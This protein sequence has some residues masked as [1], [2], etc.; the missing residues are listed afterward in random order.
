MAENDLGTLQYEMIVSD[1]KLKKSLDAITLQIKE[2]EKIWNEAFKNVGAG[3]TIDVSKIAQSAQKITQIEALE[4]GKQAQSWKQFVKERMS[5]YMR[6]EGSHAGAM[7]R[8]SSEWSVYKNS[9]S[10]NGSSK[11]TDAIV[12]SIQKLEKELAEAVIAYKKLSD[13]QRNDEGGRQALSSIQKQKDQLNEFNKTLKANIAARNEAA[14]AELAQQS[15]KASLESQ[16]SKAFVKSN[17]DKEK[18][19]TAEL[20]KQEAALRSLE[21]QR[22][23]AFVQGNLQK[24]KELTAEIRRQESAMRALEAQRSKAFVSQ[25]NKD[26]RDRLAAE[27]ALAAEQR[28]KIAVDAQEAGSIGRLRAENALMAFQIRKLNPLIA[29]EAAEILRLNQAMGANARQVQALQPTLGL[30]GKL[31]SAIRTYATAYLSV[32]AVMGLGKAVYNQ[33]KELDQLDFGMKT[34][35]KSSVE[36]ANTQKFLSEVAVNYGGDLL[37]LSERYIKFR[38]AAQQSN[39]SAAETQKIFDSMSKAAGTLGIKTD[40]LSGVYLALEQM[41]SKG[42]VTTEELRRQLGERLPGAFG[43]M[44]N[45]LGV[46][47]PEL[48]KML[49]KGEV[50]SKDALP[51]FADAIE[52]A[53]G[54][55][56]LKKIDTLAAAQGRMSTEFT[57]LIQAMNMGDAFKGTLNSIA[58]FLGYIKDNIGAIKL[59]VNSL[60]LIG[61]AYTANTLG[62]RAFNAVSQLFFRQLTVVTLATGRQIVVTNQAAVAQNVFTNAVIRAKTAFNNLGV[63]I[64]SN[65]VGLLVGAL[66]SAVTYFALMRG[67]TKKIADAMGDLNKEED[68]LVR[69]L[70]YQKKVVKEAGSETNR[71]TSAIK[72]VNTVALKYNQALVTQ[73]D[74]QDKINASINETIRLIKLEYL[75]KRKAKLLEQAET[76][77]AIPLDK[78]RETL[79]SMFDPSEAYDKFVQFQEMVAKGA[80]NTDILS[81]A[82]GNKKIYDDR[83]FIE[84]I[85]AE[86]EYLKKKAEIEAKYKTSTKEDVIAF[87]V[88]ALKKNISDAKDEFERLEE[89][90]KVGGKLAAPDFSLDFKSNKEYLNSLLVEYAKF[91]EAMELINLELAKLE[92]DKKTGAGSEDKIAERRREAL[93]KLNDRYLA[94][95]QEFADF[96]AGISAGR[97]A[98]MEDS[99]EKELKLNELAYANRL[100][101]IE[102]DKILTLSLLNDA[103]DPK[104]PIITSLDAT[105]YDAKT[106]GVIDNARGADAQ[107]R[108]NAEQ[109]L[110]EANLKSEKDYAYKIKEIRRD[111]NDQFLTGLEKEIAANNEKYDAWAKKALE[112]GEWELLAQIERARSTANDELFRQ[113]ELDQLDF[114]REIEYKK[115]E[116]ANKGSLN[117]RKLDRANFESYARFERDKIRIMKS[118]ANKDT[119]EQG[120]LAEENLLMDQKLFKIKQ[121]ADLRTQIIDGAKKLSGILAEQLGLSEQQAD[122]LNGLSSVFDDILSGNLISAAVGAFGTAIDAINGGEDSPTITALEKINHLLEQQSAIL[123]SLSGGNYFLL[124]KKQLNDYQLQIQETTKELKRDLATTS[125]GGLFANPNNLDP[126]SSQYIREREALVNRV[127]NLVNDETKGL[128]SVFMLWQSGALKLNDAQ[129]SA[130]QA[131]IEAEQ[132]II[133]LQ[134]EIYS[135][136]LGFTAADVADS[137]FTGID[138]GLKLGMD[139]LGD[140]SNSFGKLMKQALMVAITEATEKKITTDFLAKYNEFIE[141]GLTEQEKKILEDTYIGIVRQAE[142]DSANIKSITD[143]YINDADDPTAQSS[144]TK[145]IQGVTEDTARRLEGLINAMREVGVINM[146]NTQKLV[147]SAQMANAYAS[148]SL[149]VLRNIDTTTAA[150]LK[151]FNE[152]VGAAGSSGKSGLRV[153]IQ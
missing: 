79:Y 2:K 136:T 21:T 114:K 69:N 48:D 34:V 91:P 117:Q 47:I 3:G 70:N 75:E 10:S 145:S 86:R 115:N 12:T 98:E 20:K 144:V 37:T 152:L 150:Q 82:R 88:E 149:G 89:V 9:L 17:L 68:A 1:E 18:E 93:Q 151:L 126:K 55:E 103:R 97:I 27:K 130:L 35:I 141:G 123:S 76:D 139:G 109:V 65:W 95:Q 39:M 92:K 30:W 31:V 28:L 42:K 38:A 54:I 74:S 110:R 24:E 146:G 119:Q 78:F 116:I 4:N 33:T 22:S 51:K 50:L 127:N 101:Q 99:L 137:I 125:I 81:A 15:A 100:K 108:F 52:K 124:A 53:Y 134:S 104:S 112:A 128:S 83:P 29:S 14:R 66:I 118:S 138:E 19:V 102:K 147:E 72:E 107:E 16:R 13:I 41:I 71:Y 131:G 57:G 121:E 85:N 36:L 142:I 148:Q 11:A 105:G 25:G 58:S 45:A 67:E 133:E 73:A 120:R 90:T 113:N 44:A 84:A 46:T 122:V 60:A 96:E 61:I 77:R 140:F 80:S 40:E 8:M 64:K 87:D 106:Q 32:Q 63:A 59:F 7:K 111:V 26:I 6:L 129:V 153:V 43:I 49:K 5:D 135:R 94:D 143:K 62:V 23:K 56:S 132:K